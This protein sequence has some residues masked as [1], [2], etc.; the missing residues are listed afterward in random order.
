MNLPP[1][2]RADRERRGC[3]VPQPLG[4]KSPENVIAGAFTRKGDTDWAVLCSI[5]RVSTILV[6]RDGSVQNVDRLAV[7]PDAAFLQVVDY[8]THG[9]PIAG[10]SRV[11][12]SADA[13][14]ILGHYQDFGGPKPPP[15]DHVGIEDS[16]VEKSS[17]IFYW[18]QGRWLKLTGMD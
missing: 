2:V 12:G 5:Q 14:H 3:T 8:D 11:I 15:M 10:Y 1:A 13:K 9:N 17:S 7:S 18:Y 4:V 16:Y 6:Y